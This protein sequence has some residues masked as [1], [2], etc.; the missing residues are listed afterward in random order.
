MAFGAEEAGLIGSEYYTR[1]PLFP[2]KN[3]AFLLNLDL[4]ATGEEGTTVVNGSVFEKEFA[5]LKQINDKNNYLKE[6]RLRGKAAN[7][8]HYFF[9]EK[10][11]KAFFLYLAGAWAHYHHIDDKPPVPLTEFVNAFKLLRDFADKL[12]E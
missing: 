11:V 9:S 3:I 8:D 12:Q 7:S 10:G 5:L 2:L 4:F 6:I 1:Y